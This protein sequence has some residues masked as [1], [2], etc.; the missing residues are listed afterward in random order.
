MQALILAG[1]LGTRL[2]P[3]T[4]TLPKSMVPVN[5]KPFMEHQVELLKKNGMTDFVFCVGHMADK[6]RSHFGD[7]SRFGVSIQYSDEGEKLLG[8]GGAIKKAEPLLQDAFFLLYGDS[9]LLFNYRD[10]WNAFAGKPELAMLVVW[11]NHGRLEPSNL[12]IG[13]GRVTLYDKTLKTPNMV[14]INSG[15]SVLR[16]KSLALIPAGKPYSQEDFF[17]QLIDQKQLL[18]L[19]TKQRFYEIGSLAGLKELEQVITTEALA[20]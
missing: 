1:G 4:D 17:R 12:L 16:K 7:G 8:T 13:N 5:G 6:I 11:E 15:L 14:H 9:Y 19:E 18:A 10:I 3:Y 20:S 2:K